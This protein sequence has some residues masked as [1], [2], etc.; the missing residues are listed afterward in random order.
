MTA[1]GS[2]AGSPAAAP[3]EAEQALFEAFKHHQ[4]GRLEDA[5]GQY[6]RAVAIHPEF[7]EALNNLGI[8]LKD[9]RRF[10]D[11]VEEYRRALTL[12]PDIAEIWNNIGDALH[13]LG[14][15]PSAITH[16]R[17]AVALR[18]NY[19][20]AWRNLGDALQESGLQD[21]AQECFGKALAFKPDLD[22]S[23]SPAE[24][25]V[26][27]AQREFART[28]EDIEAAGA[29]D[30]LLG[31]AYF[32]CGQGKRAPEGCDPDTAERFRHAALLR[33]GFGNHL[34][35]LLL[36]LHYDAE[37]PRQTLWDFHCEVERF[38]AGIPRF[39]RWENR[40]DPER[41]LR[42]GYVSA[43]L[44]GH[45][46][47]YFLSAIF[48]HH[49]DTSVEITCYSGCAEEDE[50]TA[51]YRSR[52]ARW[53]STIE[54]SDDEL[55][56]QIRADGIDILVD[57][58]GHT[59]GHRLGVFAR[60]PAPLQVTWLGYPD[61]T[62]LSAIDYRLTDAVVDPP[63]P[64][65][66]LSSERLFRLPDGF[67][68][69]TPLASAPD[70]APLPAEKKGFVTFGSFNNLS[71]VTRPVLDVWA[72]VLNRVPGSRLLLKSRWLHMPEVC[73]RVRMLFEQRGIA[74]DRIELT[75]RL[76]ASADHL[77][78]YGDVDIALDTFPYN[79]ATTTCEALWMGVPVVTIVGDRHAARV[80]ASMLS[81]VGLEGL[82]ADRPQDYVET[83]V[84]LAAD[85]PALARLRADLRGR[86]AASP[87]CDG[88]AFTKQLE[89]AF[90]T[91]WREWCAT[92]AAP[93]HG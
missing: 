37:F 53:R 39:S 10:H 33:A 20:L 85:I 89:A 16:Y 76:P 93:G 49:D 14:D 40:R 86:T 88:P 7:P 72:Q 28:V 90:R 92:G 2:Q 8:A 36:S 70:V 17:R 34:S 52:A 69:Y 46:V 62:G 74:R 91:M 61:T 42:V 71:K 81:R 22:A 82:V 79:G 26:A 73:E 54:M 51:F 87:L 6:R 57:L 35:T 60:K 11:A 41:Q 84:R 75:G 68:C 59:S 5:V 63:G 27:D 45:S 56:A 47:G 80:G 44:R 13:S 77:A 83:A 31:D 29:R 3:A 65:D 9:Q 12:R 64:A 43:D 30:P 66:G 32:A 15:R 1:T 50:E 23:L 19:G 78:L 48:R 21:E 58:A 67:H 24:I 4:A 25:R 55:A 18:P 38:H